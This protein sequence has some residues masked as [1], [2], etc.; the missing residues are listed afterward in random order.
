M[1]EN[2]RGGLLG[3]VEA[4]LLSLESGTLP[5]K[6][7]SHYS[8][9]M[10]YVLKGTASLTADSEKY[11]CTKGSVF[12]IHSSVVHTVT[13][14]PGTRVI[15]LSFDPNRLCGREGVLEEL[16]MILQSAQNS[17]CADPFFPDGSLC[18]GT[19][20]QNFR[21][22]LS[23][24]RGSGYARDEAM[25]ACT[26][27][28]IIEIIR[29][30]IEK[31]FSPNLGKDIADGLDINTVA[32]YIVRHVEEPLRVEELAKKCKM[33]YSYFAKCFRGKYGQS[34]KEYIESVRVARAEKLLLCTNNDLSFIS[35]ELCFSDCSHLIKVFKKH[36]G[37][38]PRQFREQNGAGNDR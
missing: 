26:G 29:K 22:C 25:R 3:C 37:V 36:K 28:I 7:H 17:F 10:L 16:P 21:D 18:G 27:R 30:W 6:S 32:L 31:G 35:Q 11:I 8:C 33:S 1:A 23:E 12:F 24:A 38:T 13:S 34:C 5:Q 4:E 2:Q 19:V 20:E 15:S 14:G 9:E